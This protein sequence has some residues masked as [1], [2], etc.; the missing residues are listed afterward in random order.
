MFKIL[1]RMKKFGA[2]CCCLIVQPEPSPQ[3]EK[4]WMCSF[5]RI[6]FSFE[7]IFLLSQK[8]S[9]V[10]L[11]GNNP[12]KYEIVNKSKKTKNHFIRDKYK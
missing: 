8:W 9:C 3:R 6:F 11:G 5:T 10:S 2:I 7:G 1:S 4:K 12:V